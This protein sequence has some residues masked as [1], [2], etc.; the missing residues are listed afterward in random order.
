MK[1]CIF[2]A[3]A[4]AG[5]AAA[6]IARGGVENL[7]V[8]ARGD[9][10]AAIQENGL[11]VREWTVPIH[12]A[13]DTAALGVQ[14]F[15][16]MGLKAHTVGPALGQ[17]APLIGP[18]TAVVHMVNGIPWWYFHDLPGTWPTPYL[19]SVDPGG[20]I[21]A[22]LGPEKA[23]GCVVYVGANIPEPGVVEHN[24]GGTYIVGE[25]N[26]SRSARAQGVVALLTRG[27]LPGKLSTDIRRDVWT[28]L[29]GNLSGNPMSVLCQANCEQ[30]GEDEDVCRIMGNM[31]TEAGRVAAASGC[32]I[33]PD[34]EERLN[35][36]RSLGAIKTSMLQDFDAG[37]TIE[38]DALLGV[39]CELGGRA[40]IDT[41][42]CDMVFA[43]TRLKARAA[44][45]YQP[46][47]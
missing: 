37:K 3:G 21:A 9:H 14:D 35:T 44:G 33:T 42:T 7:S 17:L 24:N 10:L 41:P 20:R 46:L 36:F 4:V 31:M 2:G 15:L 34:I 38:L 43:L 25:P 32:D 30:L 12:A 22:A 6:R 1:T 11:T 19:D 16:I 29:W 26:G 45:C 23:V 13:D 5:L 27:G 18:Q 28:K 8:V 40:G 39:I 47:A